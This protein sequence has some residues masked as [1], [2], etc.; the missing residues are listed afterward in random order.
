MNWGSA[1]I[2]SASG[3][4]YI[5]QSHMAWVI[6]MIPREEMDQYE[7]SEYGFPN[8]LYPMEG[9]PYGA[10]RF[11]LMSPL[12]APCN[13]TPWGTLSAVDLKS[14]ELLWQKPLGTTRDLAPWPLWLSI[15]TP[16]FGGVL[17]TAGGV[18]FST[19]TT[20]H[21]VR[22]FE[23]RTGEEIWKKRTDG[24]IWATPISFKTAVEQSQ[25]V[26]VA[27][28]SRETGYSLVAYEL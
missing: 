6:K 5:N 25:K 23:A 11:P 9:T 10:L 16:N 18:V 12:G 1:A 22:A 7:A 28:S 3:I 26:V 21:F 2:D 4:L 14:G 15:G 27:V 13:K 17:A 19:G 20:D 8:Q 24:I